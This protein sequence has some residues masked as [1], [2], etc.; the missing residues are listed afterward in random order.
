MVKKMDLVFIKIKKWK[1]IRIWKNNK[2]NGFYLIINSN[3]SW[4][5]GFVK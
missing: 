4:Y 5:R 3:G 1:K 2:V